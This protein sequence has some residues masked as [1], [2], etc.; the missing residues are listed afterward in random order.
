MP[1]SHGAVCSRAAALTAVFVAGG[2]VIATQRVPHEFRPA[3]MSDAE[4]INENFQDV[5]ERIELL[6]A[7]VVESRLV[8]VLELEQEEG[9]PT[10]TTIRLQGVNV[11]VVNGLGDTQTENG[12]GNVIVGYN[13]FSTRGPDEPDDVRTGSHNLV[14][15]AGNSFSSHGGVVVGHREHDLPAVRGRD[16]RQPAT[17]QTGSARR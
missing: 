17:T 2:A 5:L 11:Q 4:Q 16:R 13:E 1:R 7:G 14:G 12:L 15:G 8:R 6:E 10:A 3:Q 9:G